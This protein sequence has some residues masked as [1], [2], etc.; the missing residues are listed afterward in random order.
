V[1]PSRVLFL[2]CLLMGALAWSASPAHAVGAKKDESAKEEGE[3][4]KKGQPETNFIQLDPF[5]VPV[6]RNG[7]LQRHVT[8]SLTIEANNPASRT[9]VEAAMPRVRDA[10]AR[11]LHALLAVVPY[12]GSGALLQSI[13]QRLARV[14]ERTVGGGLIKA[15]LL[16]GAVD[17][18]FS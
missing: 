16:Q 14:A 9:K 15:V 13:T 7:Q 3:R 4:G 8:L 18:T 6:I 17:R 11:D 12:D 10:F 5:V 1:F 2:I